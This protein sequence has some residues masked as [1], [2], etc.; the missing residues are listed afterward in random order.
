MESQDPQNDV[1]S[2]EE[3]EIEHPEADI[4]DEVDIEGLDAIPEVLEEDE[5][6][7]EGDP[8]DSPPPNPNVVSFMQRYVFPNQEQLPG[9]PLPNLSLFNICANNILFGPNR[10]QPSTVKPLLPKTVV[11]RLEYY[12]EDVEA[13]VR[14]RTFATQSDYSELIRRYAVL[15]DHA[16]FVCIDSDATVIQMKPFLLPEDYFALCALNGLEDECNIIWDKHFRDPDG[17]NGNQLLS[18]STTEIVH[19]FAMHF[20]GGSPLRYSQL[21]YDASCHGLRVLMLKCL[22]K[23]PEDEIGAVLSKCVFGAAQAEDDYWDVMDALWCHKHRQ[24][25]TLRAFCDMLEDMSTDDSVASFDDWAQDVICK[26]IEFSDD[27]PFAQIASRIFLS[28]IKDD[29]AEVLDAKIKRQL[30][31]SSDERDLH[32]LKMY[33]Y[34][35]SM[36]PLSEDTLAQLLKNTKFSFLHL[37]EEEARMEGLKKKI[38]IAAQS[39]N[40][41]EET[42]KAMARDIIKQVH[43]PQGGEASTSTPPEVPSPLSTAC[44][45]SSGLDHPDAQQQESFS[46]YRKRPHPDSDDDEE[47]DAVSRDRDFETSVKRYCAGLNDEAMERFKNGVRGLMDNGSGT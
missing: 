1:G 45:S 13:F 22:D 37:P 32:D 43:A 17:V 16:T 19:D 33:N 4:E 8:D 9:V 23:V 38:Q 7:P 40:V 10:M 44:S 24:K 31:N 47:D 25:I 3:A 35:R 5:E 26:F 39:G 21:A 14:R 34:M 42:L 6:D 27:T 41:E 28:W 36:D 18:L 20:G 30:K 46:R 2:A 29:D 11:R 15:H 12:F